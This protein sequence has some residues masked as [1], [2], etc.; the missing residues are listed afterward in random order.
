MQV[1]SVTGIAK[2][3]HEANRAVQQYTGEAVNPHWD[4]LDEELKQSA[5]DGVRG[6]I[7]G[8]TPEQSHENWCQFKLDH[9]WTYGEVKDMELK[10]HPCLVD[11][12][13]LPAE[14]KLKDHVFVAIVKSLI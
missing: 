11:Y 8:N 12:D 2:V 13:A 3:C 1:L 4:A 9:G 10:Q 14:Q 6:V 5:I 7:S